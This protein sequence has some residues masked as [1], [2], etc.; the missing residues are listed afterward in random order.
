MYWYV[1]DTKY[2]PSYALDYILPPE[3]EGMTDKEIMEGVDL[4]RCQGCHYWTNEVELSIAGGCQ[5]CEEKYK[6]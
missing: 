5:S 3:C 2:Y 4:E 1:L 6:E